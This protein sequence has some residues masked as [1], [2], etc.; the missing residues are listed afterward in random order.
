M[1]TK[2]WSLMSS[3]CCGVALQI[4]TRRAFPLRAF[5]WSTKMRPQILTE[6]LTVDM[7]LRKALGVHHTLQG[8][9]RSTCLNYSYRAW[10]DG[11]GAEKSVKGTS[12]LLIQIP[13]MKT[14]LGRLGLTSKLP[15]RHCKHWQTMQMIKVEYVLIKCLF[16]SASC[17]SKC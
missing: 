1:H 17:F 16:P 12:P 9:A 14:I 15:L 7:G 3:Q 6:P 8:R 5:L 2:S 11:W 10:G 4:Q 13:V